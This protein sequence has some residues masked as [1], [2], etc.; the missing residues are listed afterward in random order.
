M[1][2]S[3]SGTV[4]RYGLLIGLAMVL[5]WLESLVPVLPV[6]GMKLGLTNLVVLVALYR[7][8]PGP[9]VGINLVRILL[10]SMT[11]G[12]AFSLW[13]SAAGGVLSGLVML[14][15]HKSGRFGPAAVSA[16]GGVAHNVG[17]ILVAMAVLQTAGLVWYLCVLWFSG[18]A[19]GLILG[20]LCSQVLRRLPE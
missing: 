8:G 14:L 1:K 19:A 4:A 6:P 3:A 7:M 18:I 20:L 13:Y 11:F 2:K 12:N 5:S 9:A 10:V 16:A 15:L 17:Q